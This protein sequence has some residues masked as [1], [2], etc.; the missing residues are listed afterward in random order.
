MNLIYPNNFINQIIC[1][2]CSN[3]LPLIPDEVIDLIIIDP[4]YGFLL[5]DSWDQQDPINEQ[6]VEQ[7][8]RIMKPTAS[9]YCW[10]GI[11]EKNQ[12]LIRWFPI[13]SSQLIFKDLITWKKSRG[14]G[15]RK[16]WL[17]TREEIM[18]FTKSYHHIWNESAQYDEKEKHTFSKRL[19]SQ[20]YKCKSEYK[21][22]TN[23]W[24]DIPEIIRNKN[25]PHT[26]PKPIQ[27]IQRIIL[28]HSSPGDLI[29]DCFLGSGTTAIAAHN[30]GRNFIGVEI[31]PTF[32][33]YARSQIPML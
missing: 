17:Y 16:G 24:T 7:F 9:L 18:W 2:N 22:L 27:A 13:F 5:K 1:A 33:N 10:C 21:R 15:N 28:A 20:G 8:K 25:I 11:G 29:L 4:P 3:I 32:C 14:M 19:L 26:T 6:L 31:N 23:V 30:L 12:S